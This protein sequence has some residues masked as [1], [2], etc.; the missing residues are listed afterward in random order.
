LEDWRG[1]AYRIW[2]DRDR[3]SL[4]AQL[5]TMFPFA[6]QPWEEWKVKFADAFRRRTQSKRPVGVAYV[7]FDGSE[8]RPLE[9]DSKKG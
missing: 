1:D 9:S 4:K 7:W 3:P 2:I 6:D 5:M 8:I